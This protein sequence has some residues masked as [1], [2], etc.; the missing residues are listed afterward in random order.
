MNQR[1]EKKLRNDTAKL[2]REKSNNPKRMF[3]LKKMLLRTNKQVNNENKRA[4]S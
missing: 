2:N 3:C 1:S 4:C